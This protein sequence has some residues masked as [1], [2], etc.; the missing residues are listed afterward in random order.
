MTF[1][2]NKN[3]ENSGAIIGISVGQSSQG[4]LHNKILIN[5]EGTIK[6]IH[7]ANHHEFICSDIVDENNYIWDIPNIYLSRLKSVVGRCLKIIKNQEK[8]NDLLPYSFNYKGIRRFDSDGVYSAYSG[9]D[10]NYILEEVKKK[11]GVS[12]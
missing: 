11:A 5:F 3:F 10:D 1:E 4:F 12:R 2:K 9:E 8:L 6:E 7:L